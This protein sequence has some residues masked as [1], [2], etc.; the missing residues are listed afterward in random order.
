M[1]RRASVCPR[2]AALLGKGASVELTT[3]DGWTALHMACVD[4]D[5]EIFG[6]VLGA[7]LVA[8]EALNMTTAEGWSPLM[9]AAREGHTA[10]V[11]ALIA[12]GAEVQLTDENG[13]TALSCAPPPT[14]PCPCPSPDCSSL[15]WLVHSRSDGALPEC[16]HSQMP[17]PRGIL[18]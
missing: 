6:M 10:I 18:R 5:A 4:G 13:Q 11:R 1:C 17:T 7:V 3:T 16:T 14:R 2:A 15:T 8:G 9:F 12:A